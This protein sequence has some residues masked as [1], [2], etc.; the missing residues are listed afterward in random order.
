MPASLQS[1]ELEILVAGRK[2]TQSFSATANQSTTFDWDGKDAYGR[3]MQGRQV[4]IVRIG[5]TYRGVY[6]RAATYAS[7]FAL[8]GS[9]S[10]VTTREPF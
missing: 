9:A 6:T 5:Y 3:T 10:R 4:A 7:A 8:Y 1:I 2:F